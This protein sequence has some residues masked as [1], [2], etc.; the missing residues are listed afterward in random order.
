MPVSPNSAIP[1]RSE[2]GPAIDSLLLVLVAVLAYGPHHFG[3][4]YGEQDTAR[5]VVDALAWLKANVRD[6]SLSEYRYYTSPGY[7][8]LIKELYPL[9]VHSQLPLAF[10]LNTIN[11]VCAMGF[12][13][14]TY[15]LFRGLLGRLPAA[16]GAVLLCVTPAF[17]LAGLYG[18]P[19]LPALLL[20]VMALLL[21]D[22]HLT[23]SLRGPVWV[24][25]LMVALCLLGATLL[26]ADVWLSCVALLGIAIVRRQTNRIRL[27]EI[28]VLAAL[29]VLFALLL[30]KGLLADSPAPAE[31]LASW[32]IQYQ[33]RFDIDLLGQVKAVPKSTGVASFVLFGVCL[34]QLLRRREFRLLFFFTSWAIL[35]IAFWVLRPG[36]S[37]RHHLPATVPVALA[38]GWFAAGF[39]ARRWVPALLLGVVVAGNYLAFPAN[40]STLRP[41]G[42]LFENAEMIRQRVSRYHQAAREYAG[43]RTP[44]KVILG[45]FT[46]PY[47]DAEVLTSAASVI[48]VK[49]KRQFGYDVIEIVH[50]EGEKKFT[51]ASARIS[52]KE[53]QVAAAIF[54]EDGYQV[55]SFEY[56]VQGA[57]VPGLPQIRKLSGFRAGE[58]P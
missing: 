19:S 18:F 10:W 55:F 52:P 7:I 25:G 42:R 56:E 43:S 40:P 38:A 54:S 34:A 49:R 29:P 13:V 9:S 11:W 48:S 35:P 41:T 8:W 45:S 33:P 22:R 1:P 12:P 28:A 4:L 58:Y 50:A 24:P 31:Y 32:N 30:S 47:F 3:E 57:A 39:Q 17:W 6:F 2:R 44:R 15:L 51:S 26:K 27:A 5:L 21:F 36:D 37:P 46:N 16:L 14:P 23:G 53:F 20:I